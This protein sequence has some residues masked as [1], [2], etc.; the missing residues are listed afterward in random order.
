MSI[1]S[2]T[3]RSQYL[4]LQN[5]LAKAMTELHQL[6]EKLQ[7][8]AQ[9]LIKG[10]KCPTVDSITKQCQAML[11]RPYMK[12]IIKYTVQKD[13]HDIPQLA[14]D[15]DHDVMNQL[16]DTYLGKNI[17]ITDRAQW[18]DDQIILAY[19]SQ[20]HIEHVFKSMQD[21]DIGSWW[22]LYHWTDQKI[23]VH[24]FSCTIA[25]LLKALAHRRVQEAG[26]DISMKRLLAELDDIKEVVV[27]YP[28]KRG[29][30]TAPQHT[31]L[32]RT[33]ELQQSLL[34]ILHVKPEEMVPLG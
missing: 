1:F 7:D 3:V 11:S 29:A 13:R 9:G 19:R 22:P 26:I 8:R 5:D 30:K 33:S 32:S 34:S 6:S 15:I 31:V 17:I 27:P 10:G 28:R 18:N 2:K 4:T 21:R 12:S 24:S 25:V 14:Y 23:N 16:S 20:F